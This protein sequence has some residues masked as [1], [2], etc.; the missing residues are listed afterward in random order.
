MTIG[1]TTSASA[2]VVTSAAS[3]DLSPTFLADGWTAS[4]FDVVS[5]DLGDHVYLPSPDGNAYAGARQALAAGES[6]DRLAK[7]LSGLVPGE[8][9]VVEFFQM[10]DVVRNGPRMNDAWLDVS[11]CGATKASQTIRWS[12]QRRWFEAGLTFTATAESCELSF[13]ARN[14]RDG[15]ATWTFVDGIQVTTRSTSDLRLQADASAVIGPS[16]G[17]RTIRLTAENF[18]PD[19]ASAVLLRYYLPAGVSFNGGQAG[20]VP[21]GGPA[22]AAWSCQS[23][24]DAPQVVTCVRSAISAGTTD[25][26]TLT[27]TYEPVVPGTQR[28]SSFFL[29]PAF[30]TGT[31]DPVEANSWAYASV[32]TLASVC[33]DGLV[34]GDETCDDGNPT[35]SDGCSSTCFVE[36]GFACAAAGQPCHDVDECAGGNVCETPAVCVNERGGFRCA[37]PPGFDGDAGVCIPADGGG[38]ENEAGAGGADGA[39]ADGS[40]ERSPTCGPPADSMPPPVL[41]ASRVE[42]EEMAAC[43]CDGAGRRASSAFTSLASGPGLA[44][45]VGALLA[46]RSRA[47]RSERAPEAHRPEAD[48]RREP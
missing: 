20:T 24:A 47:R 37:C 9:Y 43:T 8:P 35:S 31:V 27:P 41:D 11:L 22:G 38:G 34:E 7:T 25:S 30:H 4:T 48:A 1:S 33:G 36:P 21:A 46:R 10:A 32:S 45:A 16:G 39:P 40:I 5:A 12:Q 18:G 42:D 14:T 29:S 3:N 2:S 15:D 26:L 28:N 13:A 6:T 19:A 44:L 23:N 17:T